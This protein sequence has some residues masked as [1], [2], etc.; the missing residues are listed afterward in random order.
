LSQVEIHLPGELPDV[1]FREPRFLQRASDPQLADRLA[2]GAVVAPVVHVAPVHHVGKSLFP[3]DGP[4]LREKLALAVV[5]PVRRV[6]GEPGDVE[7]LRHDHPVPSPDFRGQRAGLFELA[8]RIRLRRRRHRESALPE[9]FHGDRVQE[10][11]VDTSREADDAPVRLPE[12]ADES[13][14]FCA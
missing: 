10:R 11:R 2:A 4:Q 6:L 5:A 3:G 7:L 14:P 9:D 12:E 1:V 8:P 13:I